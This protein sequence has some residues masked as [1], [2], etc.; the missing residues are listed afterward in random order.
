LTVNP[1]AL[2]VAVKVIV[3]AIIGFLVTFGLVLW[4]SH[5]WWDEADQEGLV[6]IAYGLFAIL[7]GIP[8]GLTAGVVT[9]LVLKRR[10]LLPPRL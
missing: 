2:S 6:I 5:Q 4:Y 9:W 8:G 10:T 3:A 1:S 7:G